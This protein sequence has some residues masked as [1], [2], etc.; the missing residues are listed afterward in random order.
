MVPPD[1]SLLAL[2]DVDYNR[3]MGSDGD[4]EATQDGCVEDSEALTF[5]RADGSDGPTP[6][7]IRAGVAGNGDV[8]GWLSPQEVLVMDN[9]VSLNDEDQSHFFINAVRLDG[10]QPRRLSSI[11]EYNSY[12]V[13]GFQMASALV[14]DLQFVDN[15]GSVNRGPW[16]PWASIPASLVLALAVFIVMRVAPRLAPWRRRKVAAGPQRP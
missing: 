16:P 10:N 12:G 7:P 11:T 14:P 8:L 3:C 4:D 5:M 15:A 9:I 13:G 1:G 2:I 6:G